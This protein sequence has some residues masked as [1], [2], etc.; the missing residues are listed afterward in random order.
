MTSSPVASCD[1]GAGRPS[2]AGEVATTTG[3]SEVMGIAGS[4]RLVSNG[5]VRSRR[6]AGGAM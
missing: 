1:T 2:V 6:G 5:D 3:W 4:I